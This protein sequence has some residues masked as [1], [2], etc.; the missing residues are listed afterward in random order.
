MGYRVK[1][2][3]RGGRHDASGRTQVVDQLGGLRLAHRGVQDI[4]SEGCKAVCDTRFRRSVRLG[5]VLVPTSYLHEFGLKWAHFVTLRA[6][7]S[8]RKVGWAHEQWPGYA[9]SYST[10]AWS[11]IITSPVLRTTLTLSLPFGS[12]HPSCS[13]LTWMLIPFTAPST[14]LAGTGSP[15]FVANT[16]YGRVFLA[17]V[18]GRGTSS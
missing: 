17:S 8:W 7:Q 18:T 11:A 9:Y 5:S 15:R 6:G 13:G 10:N 14:I 3:P 1:Q 2:L 4:K 16:V 12:I